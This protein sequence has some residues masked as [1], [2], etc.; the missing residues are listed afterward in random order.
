[1]WDE[2][3]KDKKEKYKKL[4]TN[5]ASLSEAFAQK[6]ENDDIVA[7]I[8]NS[9]FQETAFQYSFDASAEDIGNTS[10]DASINES[11]ASYLVGI[12]TFGLK[13]GFQKIAQFKRESPAWSA[14]FDEVQNNAQNAKNK[15][16]ADKLN[17]E[18]YKKIA[19]EIAK[20]RNERI[21][22]S[23]RKLQGFDYAKEKEE[24]N[25]EAVYHVVMPSPKNNKP[26]LFIGETS[27]K[28]ID[29][30]S[31]E[32]D[33]CSDIKH[34]RNFKFHDKNHIYKYTSSDSQLYMDFNN[35]DIIKEK[36]SVDYLE[37][38]LSFFENLEIDN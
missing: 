30:D 12:K 3:P 20:S 33:G 18:L 14:Y 6:S 22:D 26:E 25:V 23:K 37:D 32:I 1:M 15:A 38:A 35:N 29:I 9:K 11:D 21:D 16:E 5:F 27:Y 8:V 17:K 19:I 31:L 2:L 10:Y 24:S 7:P 13:S 36:W 4:I 28:K 34:P